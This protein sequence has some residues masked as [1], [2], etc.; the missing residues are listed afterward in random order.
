MYLTTS[1]SKIRLL[2]IYRGDNDVKRKSLLKEKVL[3]LENSNP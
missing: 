3:H 2:H 1:M